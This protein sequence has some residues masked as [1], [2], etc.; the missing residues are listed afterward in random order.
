METIEREIRGA[1]FTFLPEKAVHWPERRTLMVADLHWGKA[2]IFQQAGIPVSSAILLE[3]LQRLKTLVDTLSVKR[4]VLL[5]DLMHGAAGFTPEL[6]E[7]VRAWRRSLS[8]EILFIRGN[9][10]RDFTLPANWEMDVATEPYADGPF[11]FRHHPVTES[12]AFSWCGHLHPVVHVGSRKERLRLPCFWLQ[13]DC[14][15]L[16]S[17]GSFTGGAPIHPGR[18]DSILAIAGPTVFCLQNAAGPSPHR[19]SKKSIVT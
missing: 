8:T 19:P 3:D 2:E 17:F 13:P 7:E 18:Q 9:H 1:S 15:V 16:P 5:G 12:S 6:D 11:H 4:L 14:G 10:D